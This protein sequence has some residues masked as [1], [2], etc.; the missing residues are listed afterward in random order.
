MGILGLGFTPASIIVAVLAGWIGV[1]IVRRLLLRHRLTKFRGPW[2]TEFSHIPHSRAMLG[3][4]CHNWYAQI[5]QEYG[6]S[7]LYFYPP[8]LLQVCTVTNCERRLLEAP[9]SHPI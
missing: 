5:N 7:F 9:R 4:D 1:G 8:K 2:L 3:G 6:S